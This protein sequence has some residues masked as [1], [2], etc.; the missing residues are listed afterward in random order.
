M[1]IFRKTST[2]LALV[3]CAGAAWAGGQFTNQLPNAYQPFIGNE[4]IPVD[5]NLPQGMMPQ[6]VSAGIGVLRGW[7]GSMLQST[8]LTGAT[9]TANVNTTM[10]EITPA[11]TLA[12]LTFVFPGSATA[13]LAPIAQPQDGQEF[14]I[15]STQVITAATLSVVTGSGQTINAGVTALA[16][17]T[18]VAYK[19]QASNSTWYRIR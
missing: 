13:G 6:T 2:A 3:L 15:F 4:T 7:T 14:N 5:T 1:K 17:N 19:Y 8:P 18:G 9:I 12:A 16:A 11:G 10:V